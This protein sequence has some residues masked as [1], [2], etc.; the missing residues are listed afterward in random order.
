MKSFFLFWLFVCL[1]NF[2]FLPDKSTQLYVFFTLFVLCFS[3]V[4]LFK[5]LVRKSVGIGFSPWLLTCL[6][7]MLYVVAN[8][9]FRAETDGYYLVYFVSSVLFVVAMVFYFKTGYT[10]RD[11]Y[12]YFVVL[13][14]MEAFFMVLQYFHILDTVGGY[15]VTG[16]FHNPNITAMFIAICSAFYFDEISENPRNW[17]AWFLLTLSLFAIVLSGCRT[18]GV[19]VC[20]IAGVYVFSNLRVKN[21]LKNLKPSLKYPLFAGFFVVLVFACVMLYQAKKESADGRLLIWKTSLAMVKE[22]PI[23]GYGY[24]FFD[25]HYNLKQADY[26]AQNTATDREIQNARYVRMPYNDYLENLVYGGIIGLI[27]Y[28]IFLIVPIVY[29][30]KQA[31]R[32]TF[33]V[34]L[35]IAVMSAVNF[36]FQSAPLWILVLI[37]LAWSVSQ[38]DFKPMKVPIKGVYALLFIVVLVVSHDA[39]K[40]AWGQILFV[41]A[42]ESIKK[43]DSEQTLSVYEESLP[44]IGSSGEFHCQYAEILFREDRLSEEAKEHLLTAQKYGS[45][46]EIFI[47]LAYCNY[48]EQNFGKAERYLLLAKNMVPSYFNAKFALLQFYEKTEQFEKAVALSR[49]ILAQPFKDNNK[50]ALKARNLAILILEQQDS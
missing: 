19:G 28:L 38:V 27:F 5:A 1:F 26:F 35:A 12:R 47:R 43:G 8:S 4:A 10:L 31:N 16:T 36:V 44:F 32:T 21:F 9:F 33:S 41:S 24:G 42:Q 48:K 18:A 14:S 3:G 30:A 29:A 40:H 20:I 6:V 50:D 49:E 7:W 13:G 37:M 23:L 22:K 25:K 15:S 17:R 46:P 2:Q 45:H 11:I 39:L 34:L